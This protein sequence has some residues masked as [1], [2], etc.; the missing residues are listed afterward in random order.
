MKE[1]LGAPVDGKSGTALFFST[2][3]ISSWQ[4]A[5]TGHSLKQV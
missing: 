3:H 5:V 1:K 4:G 2:G